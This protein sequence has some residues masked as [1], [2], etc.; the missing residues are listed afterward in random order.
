MLKL[1]IAKC[2][3]QA[4]RINSLIEGDIEGIIILNPFLFRRENGERL[5]VKV[6]RE[7][8]MLRAI[9]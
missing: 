4:R 5:A 8:E 6:F 1:G 7:R 3:S 2:C 9:V